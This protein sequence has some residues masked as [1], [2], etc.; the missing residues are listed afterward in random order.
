MKKTFL[1][2]AII[3]AVLCCFVACKDD[4]VTL[5]FLDENQYQ[6]VAMG[7]AISYLLQ[8]DEPMSPTSTSDYI[9]GNYI[10]E[11]QYTTSTSTGSVTI[12]YTTTTDENYPDFTAKI[13]FKNVFAE[14]TENSYWPEIKSTN[15]SIEYT[16]KTTVKTSD[17]RTIEY[18][19]K[20]I[21]I[22]GVNID[23]AKITHTP[24]S[25]SFYIEDIVIEG[26]KYYNTYFIGM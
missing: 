2:L 21:S 15:G 4:P 8:P 1:V 17:P 7:V 12:T 14:P 19:I 26:E 25:V 24:D 6:A 9:E 22:Y 20:N 18:I 13:E 11:N 3:A 23:Y 16:G 10:M 5:N